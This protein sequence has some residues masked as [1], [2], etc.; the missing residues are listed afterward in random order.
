VKL[1]LCTSNFVTGVGNFAAMERVGM[2][3][4]AGHPRNFNFWIPVDTLEM[5][6]SF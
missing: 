4:L 3:S 5:F 2:I 1:L 6:G